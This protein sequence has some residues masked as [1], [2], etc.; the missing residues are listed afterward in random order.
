MLKRILILGGFGIAFAAILLGAQALLATHEPA[1]LA[2]EPSEK[3][4]VKES[5][6]PEARPPAP[7]STPQQS[8]PVPEAKPL[9]K[10]S[11]MDL[12]LSGADVETEDIDW[13]QVEE[14]LREYVERNHHNLKL[15]DSEY[16]RLAKSIRTFREANLR[17]RSLERT[18]KNAAEFQQLL[19]DIQE[20]T[21][22]FQ[23]ITGMSQGE[24]LR[25]SENPPVRFGNEPG[26]VDNEEI[27][28]DYL[29][30]YKP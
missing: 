14:A 13:R 18:S 23:Q 21:R 16:E 10:P 24:F 29:S 27:L 28:V 25:S 19:S 8:E 12:F 30:D 11:L 20:S 2:P 17:M 4:F 9:E 22:E 1:A 3:T 26:A 5:A 6:A 7:P 15:S